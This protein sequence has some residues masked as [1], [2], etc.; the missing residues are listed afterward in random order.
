[1]DWKNLEKNQKFFGNVLKIWQRNICG[2]AAFPEMRLSSFY[3]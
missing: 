1:M 3:S 2:K